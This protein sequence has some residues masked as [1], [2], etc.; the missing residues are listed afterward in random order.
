MKDFGKRMLFFS[1][2]SLLPAGLLRLVLLAMSRKVYEGDGAKICLSPGRP[3]KIPRLVS[4]GLVTSSPG[5]RLSSCITATVPLASESQR[6]WQ[7]KIKDDNPVDKP[8]SLISLINGRPEIR[9]TSLPIP[10][11]V[12]PTRLSIH[13]GDHA[14]KSD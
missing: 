5:R 11:S 2:L 10:R 14:Y 1:M 6:Q 12:G 7:N 4:S 8:A 13:L 9:H 3:A